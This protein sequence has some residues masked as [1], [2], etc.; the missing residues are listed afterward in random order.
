MATKHMDT[1]A[2]TFRDSADN[3]VFYLDEAKGEPVAY[4]GQLDA[5]SLNAWVQELLL[6]SDTRPARPNC[7]VASHLFGVLFATCCFS[8]LT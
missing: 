8:D 2:V 7:F 3:K 6:K 5:V 4:S 1:V